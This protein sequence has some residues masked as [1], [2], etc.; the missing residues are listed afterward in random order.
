ME[1]HSAL[2]LSPFARLSASRI[3]ADAFSFGGA[4]PRREDPD[5]IDR[6]EPEVGARLLTD[7]TLSGGTTLRF[8]G[9]LSA[10]YDLVGDESAS[11]LTFDEIGET[12]VVPGVEQAAATLRTR[13][14]VDLIRRSGVT[15]S[16]DDVGAFRSD[17]RSHAGMLRGRYQF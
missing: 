3:S 16:L 8:R 10:G 6:L 13:A 1:F 14:G 11:E 9:S 15:I 4:V 7:A 12:V 17:S 2:T 5:S